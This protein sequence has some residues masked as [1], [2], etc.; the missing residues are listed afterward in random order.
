MEFVIHNDYR[1]PPITSDEICKQYHRFLVQLEEMIVAQ[2]DEVV[3][4]RNQKDS[5]ELDKARTRLWRL[6]TKR[7]GIS[8]AIQAYKTKCS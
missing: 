1:Q 4:A 7:Q 6:L 3:N 5:S 8:D 2:E